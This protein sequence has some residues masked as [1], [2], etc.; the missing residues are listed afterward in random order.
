M[1]MA[2][3]A[4]GERT[5]RLCQ[6]LPGTHVHILVDTHSKWMEV[7]LIKLS[8]SAM[9]IEK[10][11]GI[12]VTLGLPEQSV[13][14]NG[15]SCTSEEQQ[16]TWNNGV[17]YI[18]T[19]PHH[20]VSNGL[21]ERA[22]HTFKLRMKKLTEGTLETHLTHFLFHYRTTPHATTGQSPAELMFGRKLRTRLDLLKPEN[23]QC[24][25]RAAVPQE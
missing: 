17:H 4:V 9:T 22:V 3:T 19:S 1:G 20:P 10:M 13:T 23:G 14:N 7:H 11:R 16:F 15:P 6:S 8:T 21:A 2:T 5:C 12:F 25:A 18:R 24:S